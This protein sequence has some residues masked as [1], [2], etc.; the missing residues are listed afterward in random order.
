MTALRFF[1]TA[2]RYLETL[3]REELQHLGIDNARETRAGVNFSGTLADAYRVCLWSRIAGRVRLVL[4]T[5][6][7]TDAATLYE[8]ARGVDWSLHLGAQNTLAVHVDC[9]ASAIDNS[10]FGALKIKDA[11][12]DQ[13]REQSG[14]RPQVQLQQP[15]LS[16]HG[17]LHGEQLTLSLDLSG[18]A[19]HRRGYRLDSSAASLKETLAAA[20]LMRA[21]W[22]TLAAE[23]AALLDPMCGAGT[24]VL[25]AALMAADCAPGWQR[26][27]WGFSGWRGHDAPAWAALQHEAAE[28]RAAGLT[29][30]GALF[31]GYDQDVRIIHA[32]QAN[33]ERAG[34]GRWVHFER[35]ELAQCRPRRTEDRGLVVVNPPY[36][37]R[38]GVEEELPAL[39]AALGRLLREQ[40][41][42]WQAAVLTARPEW[43][44]CMGLR[45][46]KQHR[47]LNGAL[48]CRL[49]HFEVQAAASMRS[50]P[51][52]L[53]VAERSV[54]APMLANRLRKNRTAL[55]RWLN[56]E[57][58]SCYRLYDADLPEYALAIDIYTSV[59][60]DTSG[61]RLAHVQEYAPPATID[62]KIAR[63]RL[64]EAL[65]VIVDTLDIAESDLFFKVRQRHKGHAQYEKLA[66]SGR[67]FTVLEDGLRLLVNLE[68]HLDTGLFLDHRETRRLIAQQASG[69]D[70]LNLFGYTG[71]ASCHAA[72][73]GAR[74]TTTVD[75]STTYC[76]W[77][78]RN[79]ALNGF[80]A[81]AHQ[82]IQ[83]DCLTWLRQANQRRRFGLIFLDPPSFSTSK[84]MRE[85]LDI[86]RD[87]LP[88]IQAAMDWLTPEG[89]LIFTT[90]LRTFKLDEA[91]LAAVGI[92]AQPLQTI[93]RDFARRTKI[94]HSWC[95]KR[96]DVENNS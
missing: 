47:L 43:G 22:S 15:D 59:D 56:A 88:L 16:I 91:A 95:L 63:R 23:G 71:V 90:H 10:H 11:I 21:G 83:A 25:E 7:V 40:F 14:T 53:P 49:L 78:R 89:E 93:P 65:G 80:T 92:H 61:R 94:H 34:L 58:I 70:V 35:R 28:R 77:A 12:V 84:R 55:A 39:Y 38:L 42:G 52:P 75:L 67:W 33:S 66:E 4:L 81:P 46:H 30:L 44:K 86:Q 13:L 27:H 8:A 54:S 5:A 24:L 50:Q 36:G 60:P 73:G 2:P 87:H 37:E 82:V 45:A 3:L 79:L 9:V 18:E 96:E 41:D 17:Y 72:K 62:P 1:A 31:T 64:R 74:S 48:D 20:V 29:H 51:R 19:L 57:D 85:T 69:R 6:T 76:Q 68:D 26:A 32:A